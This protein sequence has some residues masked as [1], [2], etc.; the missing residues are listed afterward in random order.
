MQ[1]LPVHKDATGNGPPKL[2]VPGEWVPRKLG[3]ED[4][5]DPPTTTPGKLKTTTT[6]QSTQDTLHPLHQGAK[7]EDSKGLCR[8]GG[9]A[10]LQNKGNSEKRTNAGEEQDPRAEAERS[11]VRDPL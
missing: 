4:P 11:G 9:E 8:S 7:R 1:H 10:C 6:G 5:N 3:E 2:G